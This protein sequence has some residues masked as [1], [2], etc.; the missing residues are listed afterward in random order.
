[1]SQNGSITRYCVSLFLNLNLIAHKMG[2]WSN[3]KPIFHAR[4]FNREWSYERYYV[5]P[6]AWSEHWLFLM[7][8][9]FGWRGRGSAPFTRNGNTEEHTWIK[10]FIIE[11]QL[12]QKIKI[13]E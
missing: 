2:D 9:S 13:L 1:M 5:S 4:F 12:E 11:P 3:M 8:A 7:Q 10:S 6:I